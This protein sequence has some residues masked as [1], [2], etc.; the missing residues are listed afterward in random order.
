[1][2]VKNQ[3]YTLEVVP[4]DMPLLWS[5]YWPPFHPSPSIALPLLNKSIS[6]NSFSELSNKTSVTFNSFSANTSFYYEYDSKEI[7]C[8]HLKLVLSICTWNSRLPSF[9]KVICL[10]SDLLL[11]SEL[12]LEICS[13]SKICR[14]SFAFSI[15][16]VDL[17]SSSFSICRKYR[18]QEHKDC[19]FPL[20]LLQSL[21]AW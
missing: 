3:L 20:Q 16:L 7:N 15:K 14:F 17:H 8:T 10:P 9:L 5:C 18:T 12:D 6:T 13:T 1:M 4:F 2:I 21:L 11:C 19:M